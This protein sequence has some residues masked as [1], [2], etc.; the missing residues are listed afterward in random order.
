MIMETLLGKTACEANDDL[1]QQAWAK[2]IDSYRPDVVS[3]SIL[4]SRLAWM[5]D[6]SQ[7]FEF[8]RYDE[9]RLSVTT[10]TSTAKA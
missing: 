5:L 9:G 8:N 7:C 4:N 10:T 1:G 2:E 6:R 3:L